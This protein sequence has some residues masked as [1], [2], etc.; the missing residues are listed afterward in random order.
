[1]CLVLCGYFLSDRYSNLP[2]PGQDNSF[3][4]KKAGVFRPP[5][6]ARDFA[7]EILTER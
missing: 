5:L 2:G 4:K 3:R 1:M 7:I 6:F